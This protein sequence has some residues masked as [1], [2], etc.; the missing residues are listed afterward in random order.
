[1]SEEQEHDEAPR[2]SR[3]NVTVKVERVPENVLAMSQSLASAATDDFG[4]VEITTPW[5]APVAWVF[6][7]KRDGAKYAVSMQ[8]VF[9]AVL[10]QLQMD[11]HAEPWKRKPTKEPTKTTKR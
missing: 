9:K 2:Q 4:E 11:G 1:M 5:P 10:V 8:D 6:N 3:F 7:F